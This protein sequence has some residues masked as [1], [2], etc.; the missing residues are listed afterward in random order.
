MNAKDVF[1]SVC[2]INSQG[3]MDG[4][5]GTG[6]FISIND[7]TYIVS[8]KH[9]ICR[10]KHLRTQ[11]TLFTNVL[12]NKTFEQF[13]CT[14]KTQINQELI[15]KSNKYDIALYPVDKA[16][17]DI[18]RKGYIFN[19]Y[20]IKPDDILTEYDECD[21]IEDVIFLGYPNGL[22]DSRTN[23]PF[24][25]HGITSTPIS[26]PLEGNEE[27]IISA[28][29]YNGNSGSPI[30]IKKGNCYKLIGILVGSIRSK[31]SAYNINTS[32]NDYIEQANGE[33]FSNFTF[34]VKINNINNL[35]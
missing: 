27:F 4:G 15:I 3:E 20:I 24:V 33:F 5:Q 7:K 25:T 26:L 22:K 29:S 18:N 10:N 11:L 1:Q 32:N 9:L 19:H 31:F 2:Q 34:C 13:T 28:P 23:R 6:F 17:E 21:C 16:I 12:D 30:F 8:N 35:L 14:S